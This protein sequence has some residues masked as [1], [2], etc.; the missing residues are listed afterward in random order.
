MLLFQLPEEILSADEM[1]VED[2]SRGAQEI[3][4]QRIANRVPDVHA[5]LATGHDVVGTQH[6]ELL[7][8]DRLLDTQRVLQFLNSLLSIHQELEDL[9]PHRMRERPE[10][11]CLERL[12]LLG[13]D[14]WHRHF[15]I[16]FFAC[17]A[18]DCHA[19]R[20]VNLVQSVTRTAVPVARSAPKRYRS[21]ARLAAT[22]D[23]LAGSCAGR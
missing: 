12:K 5:F 9:D 6:G 17:Q 4:D 22:D 18:T 23:D 19:A 7:R 3:G 13:G 2:P 16:T 10:E 15:Y 21:G 11:R 20:S 1:V 14:A 8:Y